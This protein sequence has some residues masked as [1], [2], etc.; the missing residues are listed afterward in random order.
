MPVVGVSGLLSIIL[1][2]ETRRNNSRLRVPLIPLLISSTLVRCA[3][4]MHIVFSCAS[5]RDAKVANLHELSRSTAVRET[6]ILRSQSVLKA[7]VRSRR[8]SRG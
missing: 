5:L 8:L 6:F 7:G 1:L 2:N 4:L 3:A